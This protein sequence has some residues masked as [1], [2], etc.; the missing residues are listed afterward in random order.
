M[1]LPVVAGLGVMVVVMVPVMLLGV[2]RG[3]VVGPVLGLGDPAERGEG[4][5]DGGSDECDA[6]AEEHVAQAAR[7]PVAIS[8]GHWS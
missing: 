2:M 7:A 3:A 5:R 6:V 8:I 4:D 1:A